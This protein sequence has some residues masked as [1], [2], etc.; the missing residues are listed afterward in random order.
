MMIRKQVAQELLY[1]EFQTV[2]NHI[3]TPPEQLS[4]F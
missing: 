4:I 2:T 1:P 3:A